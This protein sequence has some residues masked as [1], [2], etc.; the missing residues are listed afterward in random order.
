LKKG[1]D[2]TPQFNFGKYSGQ[3]VA[4][5]FDKDKGYLRWI[6]SKD[7]STE[8]K[9]LVKAIDDARRLS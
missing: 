9:A 5:V 3:N 6:L 1:P 7:F 2:G 4:D 8:V